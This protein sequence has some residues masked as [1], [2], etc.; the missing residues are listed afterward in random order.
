[1]KNKGLSANG[2]GGRIRTCSTKIFAIYGNDA[3]KPGEKYTPQEIEFM[4][5]L[6]GTFMRLLIQTS[7]PVR[8]GERVTWLKAERDPK[9]S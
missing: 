1:M 2:I 9:H 6:T 7:K 8:A 4:I 5:Y 3:V